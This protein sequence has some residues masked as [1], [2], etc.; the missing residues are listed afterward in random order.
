M[1]RAQG[2][3]RG[4]ALASWRRVTRGRV[5]IGV[6]ELTYAECADAQEFRSARCAPAIPWCVGGAPRSSTRNST[7]MTLP[8]TPPTKGPP[9]DRRDRTAPRRSMMPSR[10]S[11]RVASGRSSVAR[12]G[13]RRG[14]LRSG[15]SPLAPA[16]GMARR[17]CRCGDRRCHRAPGCDVRGSSTGRAVHTP[18]THTTRERSLPAWRM[19]RLLSP[20]PSRLVRG[21]IPGTASVEANQSCNLGA[22]GYC[23]LVPEQR[24]IWVGSDGSGRIRETLARRSSSLLATRLRGRPRARRRLAMGRAIPPSAR[25][26]SATALR[27]SPMRQPIRRRS[28]PRSRTARLRVARRVP[29]RTSSRSATCSRDGRVAGT[30]QHA[31]PGGVRASRHRPSRQR[32]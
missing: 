2:D 4:C 9:H 27:A 16:P 17:C 23:A 14:A 12:R 21:G 6:A 19:S 31:V 25:A 3:H 29:P 26:R 7:S 15:P 10:N 5:L 1:E 32:L 13:D 18:G 8:S 30:A 24:Q 22:G 28:R 20:P 11:T